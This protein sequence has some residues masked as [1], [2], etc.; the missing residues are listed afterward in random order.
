MGHIINLAAQAF[1]CGGDPE[2]FEVDVLSAAFIRREQQVLNLWLKKRPVGKLH[3]IVKI[4]RH[5][6]GRRKEFLAT[7]AGDNVISSDLDATRWESAYHTI[8][9]A[10]KLRP[11][12]D[13][14]CSYHQ[15]PTRRVAVDGGDGSRAKDALTADDCV[16]LTEIYDILDPFR[17]ATAMLFIRSCYC[18]D[19]WICMEGT[20]Y[21]VSLYCRN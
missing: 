14:F 6:S 13:V 11:R 19:L 21:L 15:R 12:I 1:L 10:L 4:T 3:N 7:K 17:T 18:R 8:E 16:F 9:R 2:A 5:T 20:P